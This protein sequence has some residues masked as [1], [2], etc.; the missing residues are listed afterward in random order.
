MHAVP[1]AVLA[2]FRVPAWRRVWAAG[3]VSQLG[4]WMQIFARAA[5]AYELTGNPSS[6]GVVYFASYLPQLL[7]SLY[8]G[9]LADRFD[10]R[11]LLLWCQAAQLCFA[12]GLGFL[13]ATGSATLLNVSVLSFLNGVAFMLNI[14]AAQALVPSVVPRSMLSEA[15]T[16]G[17][18]TNSVTRV[19]GPVLAALIAGRVGLEWIFWVNAVSFLAVIAAWIVTRVPEHPRLATSGNL[20]AIRAAVRYVRDDAAVWVPVAVSTFIASVGIVYQPQIIP[21]A[22]EVLS[23]GVRSLGTDRAG[24]LQAAIGTGAAVGILGLAGHG[25]RRP[26]AMLTGSA[27]AF[28]IALVLLGTTSSFAAALLLCF[29]MGAAQFA[30]MTLAISLV[31]HRVPELMRGRVMAIHMAG[32]IGFVPIVSLAGGVI[33]D[34]AGI[35]AVLVGAGV[36]CLVFSLYA[37][38]W[39]DAVRRM[40]VE[41]EYPETIAAVGT[42]LEEEG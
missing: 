4:D 22:T 6:V 29:L 8:G 20:D 26:G 40:G 1:P 36:A 2:P 30:N 14:P 5:L 7:F 39:R 17:T 27:V 21:F 38:R 10:R 13:V 33:A 15:I 37:L 12:I 9:V 41:P 31:Q 19:L 23:D 28:S 25:R 11:R 42:V 32:L 35:P 3:F 16:F 18:A 24:W 34:A